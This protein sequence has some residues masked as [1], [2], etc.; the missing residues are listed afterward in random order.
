MSLDRAVAPDPYDVLP[1]VPSFTVTSTDVAD[2]QPLDE[3]AIVR[4]C[5]R[6]GGQSILRQD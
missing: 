5:I 4:R 2:G 3:L 1:V 6:C